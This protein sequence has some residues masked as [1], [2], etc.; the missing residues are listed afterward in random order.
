M[1][2]ITLD[3][4]LAGRPAAHRAICEALIEHLRALGPVHLDVVRVGVFVKATHK[5]AEIRPRARS[6]GVWIM[7]PRPV[8]DPRVARRVG[9]SPVRIAHYVKLT[10][11]D[12]VDEQLLDW[13]TEAYVAAS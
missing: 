1:P 7:L 10:T 12:N 6:V 8:D 5:L 11:L 13:L 2:G 9:V 4:C 3:E